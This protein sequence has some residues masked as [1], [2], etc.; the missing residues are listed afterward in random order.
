MLQAKALESA[1]NWGG[2]FFENGDAPVVTC[3]QVLNS[4]QE[5]LHP[6]EAFIHRLAK[7]VDTLALGKEW[8]WRR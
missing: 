8:R 6:V 5:P 4:L 3:Q 1:V 7:V 2:A